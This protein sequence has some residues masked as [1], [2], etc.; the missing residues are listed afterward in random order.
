MHLK[1]GEISFGSIKQLNLIS[2]ELE[3][4]QEKSLK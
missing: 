3:S 1:H 4:D 2:L